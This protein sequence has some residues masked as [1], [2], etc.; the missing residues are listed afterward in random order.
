MKNDF[1]IYCLENLSDDDIDALATV[2]V[3]AQSE[4]IKKAIDF[5]LENRDD[6]RFAWSTKENVADRL[7]RLQQTVIWHRHIEQIMKEERE[8]IEPSPAIIDTTR[9]SGWSQTIPHPEKRQQ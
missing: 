9:T 6:P 4:D 7:I 8:T 5:F 2:I 1:N 3:M